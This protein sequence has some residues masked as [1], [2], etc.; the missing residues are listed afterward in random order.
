[1]AT[2]KKA[3]AAKTKQAVKASPRKVGI[4]L[5]FD[6]KPFAGTGSRKKLLAL[7]DAVQ[8][9]LETNLPLSETLAPM[10]IG[11][12]DAPAIRVVASNSKKAHSAGD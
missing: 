7:R 5:T 4:Q 9:A 6:G 3:A 10:G 1:M 11:D 8:R 12:L 2:K